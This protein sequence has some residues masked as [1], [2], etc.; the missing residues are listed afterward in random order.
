MQIASDML[1]IAPEVWSKLAFYGFLDADNWTPIV[2]LLL[3]LAQPHPLRP[4][5]FFTI[6]VVVPQILGG[7]A[8]MSGWQKISEYVTEE[9][10]LIG[11]IIQFIIGVT[12]FG[13]AMFVRPRKRGFQRISQ[14]FSTAHSDLGW[15]GLG[16]L[17]ELSKLATAAV[18]VVASI[19]IVETCPHVLER[20][21]MLGWFNLVS[22]TPFIVIWGIYLFL[23]QNAQKILHSAQDWITH[24]QGLLLR[25]AFA[26]LG[27][28]FLYN[29]YDHVF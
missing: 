1:A 12:L 17:V 26:A 16:I 7:V 14:V 21:V 18:Y 10:A 3:L 27:F 22:L 9:V 15:L 25:T 4:A 24:H 19:L 6:G 5:F 13:L 28:F 23:A 2:V 11:L 29:V 8:Y 20:A